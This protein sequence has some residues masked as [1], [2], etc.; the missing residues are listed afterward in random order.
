PMSSSTGRRRWFMAAPAGW[1]NPTPA[2][3]GPLKPAGT[4]CSPPRGNGAGILA[5]WPPAPA[6]AG[7]CGAPAVWPPMARGSTAPSC[8]WV[9]GL[10]EVREGRLDRAQMFYFDPGAVSAFLNR[11]AR[12]AHLADAQDSTA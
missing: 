10:Y 9:L 11:A 3:A 5:W 2:R 8:G 1:G 6:R 4:Q 12:A 7:W